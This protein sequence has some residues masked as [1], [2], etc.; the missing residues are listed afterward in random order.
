MNQ[1]AIQYICGHFHLGTP[2]DEPERVFGG[3]IHRMWQINTEKGLFAVKELSKFIDF[4]DEKKKEYELSEEIS[5]KLKDEG[6]PAITA[7]VKDG[8]ALMSLNSEHFL[9][10]PWVNGK[11][12]AQPYIQQ[13]HCTKMGTC[14]AR[15]HQASMKVFGTKQPHYECMPPAELI[16]L[17]KAH[18]KMPDGELVYHQKALLL[19]LNDHYQKTITDLIKSGL[20][21][22]ADL[23]P[24]NVLWDKHDNPYF[25][26][27][28]SARAINRTHDVLTLALDWSGFT[29]GNGSM[30]ALLK[31]IQAYQAKGEQ[32][33]YELLD[34]SFFAIIGN[35]LNWLFFNIK[36]SL[37]MSLDKNELQI[38]H[39]EID[40]TLKNVHYLNDNFLAIKKAVFTHRP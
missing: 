9:A 40:K 16:T 39:T 32:I 3:L 35:A 13:Y 22:H 10:Y 23:D 11:T 25:I 37:D 21:S 27:W 28:E 17:L 6:I 1:E 20:I 33:D 14:L 26:D 15:L 38:A 5:R 34:P 12:V 7:L 18:R 36:R 30:K 29:M 24:K 19:E 31:V 4:N 8:H 2:L